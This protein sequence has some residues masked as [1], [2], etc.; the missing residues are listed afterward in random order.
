MCEFN[1][2]FSFKRIPKYSKDDTRER[3]VL[4]VLSLNVGV[5]I[6]GSGLMSIDLI[7]A[8]FSV[9]LLYESPL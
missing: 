3:I 1:L 9:G 8:A 7:L 4:E 6:E 5:M 2:K